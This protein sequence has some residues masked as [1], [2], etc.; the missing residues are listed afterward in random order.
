MKNIYFI[1]PAALLAMVACN[2]GKAPADTLIHLNYTQPDIQNQMDTLYDHQQTSA[3]VYNGLAEQAL[4]VCHGADTAT[5]DVFSSMYLNRRTGVYDCVTTTVFRFR[6]GTI[7]ATGVFNLTPGDTIA[8]DHNFPI[9]GG[10]GAYN[11]ISGTYTRH[12]SN[13]VYHVE[14][15][16]FKLR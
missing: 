3:G 5:Q 15:R 6:N 10:S 4:A 1:L 13:G 16:Y 9:T 8:P 11:D 12:Y 7:T 14:L 2:T